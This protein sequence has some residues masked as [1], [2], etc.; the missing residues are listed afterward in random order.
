MAE[1]EKEDYAEAGSVVEL[2]AD[3]ASE[4]EAADTEEFAHVEEAVVGSMADVEDLDEH[5]LGDKSVIGIGNVGVPQGV[6]AAVG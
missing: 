3:V 6:F 1:L 2:E 5:E 4:D